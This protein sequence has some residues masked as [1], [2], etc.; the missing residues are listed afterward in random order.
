[1]EITGLESLVYGVE[2]ME[3][4]KRFNAD[5]GLEQVEA[6]SKGAVFQTVEG[7]TVVLRDIRD[8]SLPPAVTPGPQLRQVIWGVSSKKVLDAVGAELS[9]DRAVKQGADGILWST[10]TMGYTIGFRV[11][12]VKDLAEEPLATNVPGRPSRINTRFKFSERPKVLHLGHVVFYTPNLEET[13]AFYRDRLGFKLSDTFVNGVG[14][15]L[16]SSATHDHH[17]IFMLHLGDMKG[18]NHAS[19]QVRNFDDIAVAGEYLEKK[20]WKSLTG[21]G[22]HH[23]GSNYFWYFH[24]P[25]GG[26]VEYHSDIDYL[27]DD[28][29]PREWEFRPDVA[30][31]WDRGPG[32][33]GEAKK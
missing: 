19:Y 8:P 12:Q 30:A 24:S 1:M 18:L 20:G 17:S 14:Y 5:F 27:T 31:A 33:A 6:D 26:A 15:F 11:K 9:K 3:T 13:N 2:D 4:C 25:C 28:W 22:R 21:P 32:F 29:Q 10:D 7:S 23:I 16:R